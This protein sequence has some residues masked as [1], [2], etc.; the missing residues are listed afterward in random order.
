MRTRQG[1]SLR[2][3]PEATRVWRALADQAGG[4]MT[5]RLELM[6]HA[7]ATHELVP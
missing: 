7:Q 6:I 3:R 5:E 2:L 1:M 4:T